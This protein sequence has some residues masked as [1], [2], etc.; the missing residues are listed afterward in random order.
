MGSRAWFVVLCLAFAIGGCDDG[1][2][3][4]VVSGTTLIGNFPG[5]QIID[6]LVSDD[7]RALNHSGTKINKG[8]QVFW[9]ESN[10]HA[11]IIYLDGWE[12]LWAHHWDGTRITPGVE[13]RGPGQSD[14]TQDG[15]DDS[16][17]DYEIFQAYRVLFLNTTTGGRNGDAIIL[18]V[19]DDDPNPADPLEGSN[20]RLYGT[21]F[22][23]SESGNATSAGDP[24]VHY[25][26]ESSG[27]VIDF[28][29][30]NGSVDDFGFVSDSL[31]YTHGYDERQSN[32]REYPN[33]FD[34]G[35]ENALTPATRSGDPTTFVW[36][37]WRKDQQDFT[38]VGISPRYHA[39]QFN[40]AQVGNA[41][42]V[43]ASLGAGTI[44]PVAG[45]TLA[46]N[47]SVDHGFLA[48][49]GCMV[50]RSPVSNGATGVF[51]TCFNATG[52]L[53]TIEMS[54][55]V[56]DSLAV[57]TTA[58][59]GTVPNQPLITNVYGGDHGLTS[60]YAF[61]DVAANRVAAA[62][63]DLDATFGQAARELEQINSTIGT[64]AL[65]NGDKRS[66]APETRIDR[67][68]SW[69][70]AAWLQGTL[71]PPQLAGFTG[72][73]RINM[74]GIQTRTAATA[75]TLADSLVTGGPFLV[76]NQ[77][78]DVYNPS[79]RIFIQDELA[80][81]TQGARSGIQSNPNRIN[82]VW[83]EGNFTLIDVKHNGLTIALSTSPTTPPTGAP[84]LG[85]GG[86]VTQT[87][88][89][90]DFNTTVPVVVTDLGTAAGEPLIYFV[91]NANNATTPATVGAFSEL[92]VFGYPGL[93]ASTP[94]D[95]QLVST[96]GPAANN[97]LN[98]AV[99]N[100]NVFDDN[101]V[102]DF[103]EEGGNFL[104]VKTTPTS[105]ASGAFGGT[106]VHL[107]WV[108]GR[109]GENSRPALKTRSFLK[110]AFNLAS[111]AATFTTAHTPSLAVAPFGMGGLT[112]DEEFMPPTVHPNSRRNNDVGPFYGFATSAA[113]T[114]GIY[115]TTTGHFWYQ[116]F[117]GSTWLTTPEIIDNESG[118]NLFM[119]RDQRA[120]VFPPSR[121]GTMD[122]LS[123][124]LLIYAKPP[125][126][127][128][129]A[130]RRQFLRV[131]D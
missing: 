106:R 124:T 72:A 39:I 63:L 10:G 54:Q 71:P 68:N 3:T 128:D 33:Q 121:L 27:A 11:I 53:G 97:S 46:D 100:N 74:Q 22:D 94:A 14:L 84:S 96:D 41:L 98:R 108:E 111:P 82:F 115:F 45:S 59:A 79:N 125:P 80:N 26:F 7:G 120:C 105:T 113:N 66:W 75:R 62:K 83:H 110:S 23:V 30:S 122:N 58:W 52:N 119:G 55:S 34:L 65:F 131:R 116:E 16:D 24:T 91:N 38:G 117:N 35:S 77:A 101:G 85:A 70:F 130:H 88:D 42:P 18:W 61:F 64:V 86:L 28:N 127:D 89:S 50:W 29:N 44:D 4:T 114:V 9:N 118:A 19:C 36:F 90:W 17:E 48:H 109:N 99:T 81:G 76:P 103:Y 73:R 67:T 5:T 102:D 31:R 6:Y 104:R 123:G 69:I 93:L 25:G 43:Q 107:F 87:S 57:G 8:L 13:L 92:R 129:P 56:I 112:N 78:Q 1:G 32:S 51:A 12:R 37:I 126:G 47:Q 2:S 21:Y 40:L 15:E 60:L 49:N 95:A 20:A